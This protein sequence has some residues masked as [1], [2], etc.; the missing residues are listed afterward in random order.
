MSKRM[1]LYGY[2]QGTTEALKVFERCVG[3]LNSHPF[4]GKRREGWMMTDL[5]GVWC[6]RAQRLLVTATFMPAPPL[7]AWQH[8][9]SSRLLYGLA[10]FH[11]FDGFKRS[12]RARN[13]S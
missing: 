13:R 5:C 10:D 7:P 1:R 12:R 3:A 6:E 2:M 9:D 8:I 11:V 4:W